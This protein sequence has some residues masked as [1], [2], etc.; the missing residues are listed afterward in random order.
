V[1]VLAGT[2]EFLI[3]DG[4]NEFELLAL[5]LAPFMIG[6][7]VLMTVP[8]RMVS[9]LGRLNLIFILVIFAP[10]NPP[11]YNPQ[12]FLFSCLFLGV[13]TALLLAAQILV[14][15]ESSE[16]RQRW[17]MASVRR[18]FGEVLSRTDRHLLPEEAMFRDATR[19]SQ[20]V[21]GGR[22][23]QDNAVVSEAVSYFDRAAAIRL[24]RASL[25]R[26]AKTSLS[27][28][29]AD[30][31]KALATQDTER[32]RNVAITLNDV[33]SAEGAVAEAISG[34]LALAAIVIDHSTHTAAPTR[35]NVS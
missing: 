7:A 5:A 13:A 16:R 1:A 19:I 22:G 9:S 23:S 21:A 15:T 25:D 30:A 17:L 26:L 4:V 28:L 32:L 29:A 2:L 34:E 35:E 27:H 8:N 14:P 3:L 33:A 6:V 11:S 20:I 18:G 31:Q 10:S 24:C 12:A